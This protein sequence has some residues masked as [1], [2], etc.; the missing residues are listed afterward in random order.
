MSKTVIINN[1]PYE[2]PENGQDP[3]WGSGATDYLVE[4][5]NVLNSLQGP[6]DI[7]ETVVNIPDGAA[8]DEV[9]GLVFDSNFVKSAIIEYNITN[10]GN[11]NDRVETGT[12][13]LLRDDNDGEWQMIQETSGEALVSFSIN[14]T[15][16]QVSY[17]SIDIG[18]P[19][20][21]KFKART[22]GA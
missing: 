7:L 11:V 20:T 13:T 3:G 2:I 1:T 15:T 5:A 4:I 9:L 10:G 16:G 22:L 12:I 14:N 17:T 21:L 8:S 6:G 18:F 19:K